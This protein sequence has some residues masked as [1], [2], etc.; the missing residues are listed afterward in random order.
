VL[1][2]AISKFGMATAGVAVGTIMAI[3]PVFA[4][5]TSNNPTGNSTLLADI[6]AA[7]QK[8]NLT[9]EQ[10]KELLEVAGEFTTQASVTESTTEVDEDEDE[11]EDDDD[12]A[13]V[14]AATTTK[15]ETKHTVTITFTAPKSA[16]KSNEEKGDD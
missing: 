3:S 12:T 16:E 15:Q 5:G 13:E 11:D 10:I 1:R 8:A 7:A 2:K 4:Q 14:A 6:L 9:A